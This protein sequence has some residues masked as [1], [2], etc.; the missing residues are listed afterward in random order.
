M[1][2]EIIQNRNT[3]KIE[4]HQRIGR[5]KRKKKSGLEALRCQAVWAWRGP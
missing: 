1:V 2:S 3:Y 4:I 5:V